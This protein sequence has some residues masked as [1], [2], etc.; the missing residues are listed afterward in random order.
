M[1]WCC[2][3]SSF[4]SSLKEIVASQSK[5]LER[6]GKSGASLSDRQLAAAFKKQ[7]DAVR[8]VLS[9]S[10][11]ATAMTVNFDDA[12]KDPHAIAKKVNSFL[13]GGLDE[14]AMASQIDGDLRHESTEN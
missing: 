7:V 1:F 8:E 3:F 12:I 10:D 6:L 14:N 13:G 4:H 9:K 5:M 2:S 11:N